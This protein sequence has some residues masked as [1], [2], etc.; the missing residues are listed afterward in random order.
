MHGTNESH[1]NAFQSWIARPATEAKTQILA[2]STEGAVW[3]PASGVHLAQRFSR[4][5]WVAV[6]AHNLPELDRHLTP[7]SN[8]RESRGESV[9]SILDR[10]GGQSTVSLPY[11]PAW[12]CKGSTGDFDSPS[13]GSNPCRAAIRR[14]TSCVTLGER[15]K[16]LC[17]P[18]VPLLNLARAINFWE[19]E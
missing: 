11:F 5:V 7:N 3:P 9:V 18:C 10:T 13:H 17:P 12:W 19:K 15:S 16:I 14:T 1:G 6:R 8:G 4:P 2:I